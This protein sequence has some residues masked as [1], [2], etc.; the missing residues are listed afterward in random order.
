MFAGATLSSRQVLRIQAEREELEREKTNL[1]E[2]IKEKTKEISLLNELYSLLKES[3]SRLERENEEIKTRI[4]DR[5]REFDRKLCEVEERYISELHQKEEDIESLNHQL[6]LVNKTLS[7]VQAHLL[8][9]SSMS[10]HACVN[11]YSN[12]NFY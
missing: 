7:E 3:N 12:I 2:R 1:S 6:S 8:M 9:V 11:V 10:G 5:E 4:S